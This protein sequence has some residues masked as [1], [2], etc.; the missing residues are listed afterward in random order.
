MFN[1]NNLLNLMQ[2]QLNNQ[3]IVVCVSTGIDSMVLLDI[4]QKLQNVKIVV[5]HVNHHKRE[6]SNEEQA[7][8]VEYCKNN[9]LKCYVEE[10]H[11]NETKNFQEA[12][13]IKRYQFFEKVIK[14][15]QAQYLLTAHHA[16]DN[17]ETILIRLIK[18]S[19][20]KGYA[21]IEKLQKHNDYYIYR[22]LINLTKQ[23]IY[24]YQK[25]NN[26]KFF[27]DESNDQDDYLRNRIRHNIIPEME[28]ENPSLYKAIEIYQQHILETNK[29]LFEKINSF[30]NN[31]VL[32]Q[33]NIISFKTETF[34][35][36]SNYLQEQILF[37]ILKKYSLSKTLVEE[38]IEQIKSNKNTIINNISK[39][40]TMVK[41]YGYI[42]FGK[43]LKIDDFS[44]TINDIGTYILPN[45]FKIIV[46]KNIC[47]FETENNKMCYNVKD[48]PITIRTRKDGDKILINNQ[49]KNLSDYLTNQKVSHFVRE[50]LLVVTNN[51]NQVIYL[52]KKE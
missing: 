29:L 26:I 49:L 9:N 51:L 27:N 36:L 48:L 44:L 12:A 23:D 11:F 50:A 13:R 15:E 17:L 33:N 38:L 42:K 24:D 5:A 35:N 30:I 46:D 10:L 40:L 32:T 1:Q 31:E 52:I 18:S 21:G 6:Q 47:Y 41:E 22:P 37:E 16:V 20:H 7:Y 14:N 8:I 25:Q 34:N 28:K 43:L 39:E 19:S 3:T 2:E 45:D 4:V